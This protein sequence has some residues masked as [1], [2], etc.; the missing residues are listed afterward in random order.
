[1]QTSLSPHCVAECKTG[2]LMQNIAF[3]EY[4]KVANS[5]L[6]AVMENTLVR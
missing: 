4:I 3:A 5:S 6:A 1:V 2:G